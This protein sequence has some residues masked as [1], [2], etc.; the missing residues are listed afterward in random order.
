MLTSQEF[1]H[2]A[3]TG[4]I[5]SEI[6]LDMR[7]F[8]P[9]VRNLVRKHGIVHDPDTL[10]PSDDDLMD[11]AWHAGRELF[12]QSGVYGTSTKRIVRIDPARIDQALAHALGRVILG[13]GQYG[14]QIPHAPPGE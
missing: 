11:R 5:C 12:L 10:V 2:Q 1:Y 14:R 4:E 9:A 8:V 13:T 6:D 7:R 3:T